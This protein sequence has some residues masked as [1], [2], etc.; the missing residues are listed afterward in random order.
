[1]LAKLGFMAMLNTIVIHCLCVKKEYY[2]NYSTSYYFQIK[3]NIKKSC[4]FINQNVFSYSCAFF[5]WRYNFKNNS[6]P[7]I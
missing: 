5:K 7:M 6:A 1:M 2:K 3:S 4:C